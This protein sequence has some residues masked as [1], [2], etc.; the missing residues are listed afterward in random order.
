MQGTSGSQFDYKMATLGSLLKVNRLKIPPNQRE[1]SWEDKQVDDLF[2]DFQNA[3]FSENRDYFLGTIV[4]SKGTKEIPEVVDGQQ[5]LATTTILLGAIRDYCFHNR[6]QWQ[7]P[8]DDYLV[9]YDLKDE[10]YVPNL[11]LNTDDNEYFRRRVLLQPDNEQRKSVETKKQSHTKIDKACLKA[12]VLVGNLVKDQ[13]E[14]NAKAVLLSWL[15]F[16]DDNAKI[17]LLTVPNETNAFMMFETLNDRGLKTSQ[18]DLVKNYLFSKAVNMVDAQQKWSRMISILETVDEDLVMTYL[19]HLVIAFQGP[20][21]DKEVFQKI[22]KEVQNRTQAVAFL[23]TL[24]DY[25]DAYAAILT[26]THSKWSTYPPKIQ[27]SIDVIKQLQVGQIRPLMLAVAKHF[28]PTEADLAFRSFV[29]WTVRFLI[30]GGMRGGQLEDAY[31]EK[32]QQVTQGR[33]KTTRELLDSLRSQIPTDAE[34]RSTFAT[35][36]VSKHHLARYYLSAIENYIRKRIDA[37][38]VPSQETDRVNLEHVIPLTL[39]ENWSHIDPEMADAFTN[40]IGNLTLLGSRPNSESGNEPFRVKRAWYKDSQIFITHTIYDETDDQTR[41]GPS[42]INK[43][44]IKLAD[45]AVQTW[46]LSSK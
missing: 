27:R 9:T 8:I 38:L 5:R 39:G 42:E 34:F 28:D 6:K 40:R 29:S 46:P 30:V 41:W 31:G 16:I 32:A 35:A 2:Q 10:E 7:K 13:N 25:A 45:I 11:T 22:E 19:R 3:I 1:Y 33:S 15:T 12:A 36:R 14:R 44:Q 21:R 17:M 18:A 43:R 37:E 4:V 26:P 23:D 20:T 24:A